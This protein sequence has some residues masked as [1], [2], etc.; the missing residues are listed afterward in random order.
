MRGGRRTSKRRSS[1]NNLTKVSLKKQ[2]GGMIRDLSRVIPWSYNN[3]PA[4]PSS[5]EWQPKPPAGGFE[6]GTRG[7]RRRSSQRK[8]RSSNRRR[9]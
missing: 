1:K 5:P 8:R 7:G 2:R 6:I 4:V 3:T 9:F